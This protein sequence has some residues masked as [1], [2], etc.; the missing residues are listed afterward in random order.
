MM[1]FVIKIGG[2]LGRGDKLKGLCC[3]LAELGRRHRMLIV[4]GGGAFADTVRHYDS[5]YRLGK[6]ASHWMAILAMDQFGY[7][8]SELIPGSEPVRSLVVAR[9]IAQAGKLPVLTPFDL[10]RRADP[11]PHSWR[12]TSDSIAAWVA[13]LARAHMLV[14]LKDVDGLYADHPPEIGHVVLLEEILVEHLAIC[15]GV[16]PCL[17]SSLSTNALDLWII[18]GEK[19]GR[20]AELLEKGHTMGTHL[21]R[22]LP[23]TAALSGDPPGR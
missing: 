21:K 7:L 18:N 5:R 2:S 1:E 15:Q 14:L 16:D 23:S 10:L 19:P 4:P 11:L 3:R 20:L 6:S 9:K 22:S 12:V 17:A 8:L 13:E